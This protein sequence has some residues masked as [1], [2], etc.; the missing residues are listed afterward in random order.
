MRTT[1]K[2]RAG[3]T[4]R[5]WAAA[6]ALL[7]VLP[8]M[9]AL[10]N[11][12]IAAENPPLE[13]SPPP[14]DSDEDM[15]TLD[16]KDVELSVVIATIASMTKT[17][18]IYDDRVRGRVTIVSPTAI[19]RSQAYAV[20]ESVLQ[21]KG[22]T[23]V[24]TPGGA[25][26]VI[27]IRDAKESNIRTLQSNNPPPNRDSYLTQLIPLQYIDAESIVST[28]QP[29]VSK[30]AAMAAYGPTNTVI[31]T[32]SASNIR[33]I[34]SILESID[35]ENYRDELTVMRIQHADAGT[36]ADQISEIY[37]AEVATTAAG[38][39]TRAAARR[40]SASRRGGNPPTAAGSVSPLRQVRILTD[41]RTNSL[42]VLAARNQLEDI[43]ELVHK[44][45]VPIEGG[46]RIRVYYLKHANAE[47]LAQ[48]LSSLITGG[49]GSAAAA[50]ALGGAQAQQL[51]TAV[52]GLDEGITI[53]AD[54]ATNS[55]V[56]RASKE[57]YATA[58]AVIEKLDI[59]RP[60]VLVEA[61]IME[62]NVTDGEELGFNGIYRLVTD[63][64]D[65][66]VA[67]A[68]DSNTNQLVGTALGGPAGA[69]AAPFITNFLRNTLE[70]DEVT[71]ETSG[72]LI[73][74]IIRASASE[75]GRNIVA[76]PHILTSDNE[77]AEIR[78]GDNIP[79]ISSR[80]E[81]AQGQQLGLSTSVNVERQ[82]IGVTLRVTPQ[83]TE[84][85]TL[86]LDIYQEI[87][88][89]NEGLISVTGAAEDVGVPLSTRNIEN[90]VV[91]SDGETIVVGGLISDNYADIVS[92][93]P[94]FGD[95]PILGWLFKTTT[96][97]LT[98]TNLLVFLTPH[99]IRNPQDLELETIR[100]REEFTESA[101]VEIGRIEEVRAHEA[102]RKAEAEAA[103]EEYKPERSANPVRTA[104]LN[105]Q[106]RYPLERMRDIE[107]A[108]RDEQQR[109][110]AEAATQAARAAPRY[111]LQA[112]IYS[113]PD[114]AVSK[115]TELV[116]AGYDGNLVSGEVDGAVLYQVQLGPFEN[117]EEAERVGMA[118][119]RSH[120]LE[121]SVMLAPPEEP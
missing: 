104:V 1:S 20:F 37:G 43:R 81:S 86:R 90:T 95:I 77:E 11:D 40:T 84:G 38:G 16:F 111:F 71:G 120:G 30:D 47:E 61:L 24:Q 53:T 31:L 70:T 55:L 64:Y 74:G 91:V 80:V 57:G 52:A 98:K 54:P 118:L 82:D 69:A 50:G 26:K 49:G 105:H 68:T 117:V 3:T 78:I 103:G 22:F 56:I 39:G 2:R 87:S 88:A 73:Q 100:K 27:P 60:Q 15:V 94:W 83:I 116:D 62:V 72:T 6:A 97:T 44:L 23:T 121:P 75:T 10:A 65:V 110:T 102:E 79:I 99:I 18:F 76:A 25:M 113:D 8:M 33:R 119:R 63:T 36:L 13:L 9:T 19:P 51:R 67:S 109:E 29:L 42:I 21:V 89:I 93:V 92:K 115:L 41:D 35:V 7:W 48:T 66:T 14:L 85:N 4:R 45:D 107:Q 114:A 17:N 101:G 59:Q 12:V 58:M 34:L 108:Q 112:A 106:A 28:L 32:E 96:K 5:L 46:G